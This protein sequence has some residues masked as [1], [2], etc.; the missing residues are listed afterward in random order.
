MSLGKR[1]AHYVK[2]LNNAGKTDESSSN[3]PCCLYRAENEGTGR[4]EG[5][6]AEEEQRTPAEREM[7]AVYTCDEPLKRIPSHHE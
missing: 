4:R 6:R 7:R 2:M 1:Q 5:H 3:N